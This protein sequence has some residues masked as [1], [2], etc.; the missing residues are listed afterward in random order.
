M[1]LTELR[2]ALERIGDELESLGRTSVAHDLKE[3]MR[4]VSHRISTDLFTIAWD[5]KQIARWNTSS[6]GV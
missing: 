3:N 1:T 4:P 5:V 6:F 2:V